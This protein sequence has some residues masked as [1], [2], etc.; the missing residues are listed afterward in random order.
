MTEA[1]SLVISDIPNPQS[2][3][4]TPDD[5]AEPKA[6]TG[7]EAIEKAMAD[8]EAKEGVKIGKEEESL[9]NQEAKAKEAEAKEPEKAEEPK[10]KPERSEN[11]TFKAKEPTAEQPAP[12]A[13]EGEQEGDVKRP[14]EGRDINTPPAR[15]ILKAKEE[16]ATVPASVRGEVYRTI[17]NME[18][19]MQEYAQ[20]REFRK[21][22][23]QYDELA[24]AGGTSLPRVFEEYAQVYQQLRADP[25]AAVARVLATVGITPEQYANHVLGQAQQDAQNPGASGQRQ[26]QSE[27]QQLRNEL[28]Q[29]REARAK[30]TQE[31]A[32]IVAV[33][34]VENGLF[35]EVRQQHPRFDELRETVYKLWNS[36]VL[37][38]GLDE[39][40]RLYEA[41]QM[42]ERLNPVSNGSANLAPISS[43]NKQK[44][45][46]PAGSKSV[47][48][49][50]TAGAKSVASANL[51][52]KEAIEAAMAQLGL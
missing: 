15:F 35:A 10:A 23:K 38:S 30:A 16:W 43:A 34:E 14:S 49:A 36:D 32:R 6:D 9:I 40:S 17:E 41:V 12:A 31:Q 45:L 5:L 13:G 50:P 42:A 28:A 26:V 21:E 29:E 18:K 27:L 25:A 19:G 33:Q 11:G 48:G 7:R 2:V 4:F 20:D 1:N 52:G 46:N 44:P 8:I 51:N 37:P 22:L 47:R 39:R 24:K 3:S